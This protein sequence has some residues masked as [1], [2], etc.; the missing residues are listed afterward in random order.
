MTTRCRP[1]SEPF[2][3]ARDPRPDE[4][5]AVAKD[6]AVRLTNP[7]ESNDVSIDED[8][9]L[10]IQDKRPTL[11]FLLKQRGELADVVALETTAHGQ[12]DVAVRGAPDP[13]HR[14]RREEQSRR[15]R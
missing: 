3:I 6:D 15:Q 12:N 5:R 4:G 14:D 10:E 8:D 2:G 1:I 9:V 13:Q 7:E 11:P